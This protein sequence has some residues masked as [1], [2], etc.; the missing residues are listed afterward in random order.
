MI[1]LRDGDFA[2][3]ED[4]RIDVFSA[5]YPDDAFDPGRR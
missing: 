1:S 5:L 2:P 3:I 4:A